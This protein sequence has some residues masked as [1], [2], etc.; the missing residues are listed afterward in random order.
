MAKT[1]ETI[2]RFPQVT[3]RV[4]LP[5]SSIYEKMEKNEFPKPIKLGPKA[6]GWVSSEIEAWIKK[7][8][9]ERDKSRKRTT[10]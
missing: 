10:V 5:R 2:L 3:A 9:R 4:G 8:I 7:Q 1:P 6:I